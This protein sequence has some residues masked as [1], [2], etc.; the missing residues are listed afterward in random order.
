[1][2]ADNQIL[3]GTELLSE[4]VETR[5]A[6]RTTSS[7]D[8]FTILGHE[9]R[10]PLSALNFALEAWPTTKDEPQLE[11]ELLQ[12]MRRQVAQLTRLCTDMLDAGKKSQADLSI[13]QSTINLEQ[14]IK[15]ACEEIRPFITQCGLSI[16]IANTEQPLTLLGDESKLTQVFANLLHNAAKFTDQHGQLHIAVAR[17]GDTAVVSVRDSGCGMCDERVQE[18]FRPPRSTLYCSRGPGG[19][20][21]IGLQLAKSIVELHGG[22]IKAFSE[23]TGCGSEFVVTLPLAKIQNADLLTTSKNNFSDKEI[24]RSLL[25]HCL[26]VVVDDDRSIRFLMSRLL[27]TLEQSVTVA[28]SGEAA[29]KAILEVSPHLVFMDLQMQ[30]MSGY[31]LAREVRKRA[32][33]NE[34]VLIALSGNADLTSR[35]LAA[36]SGF[37]Q[38]LVKPISVGKLAQVIIGISAAR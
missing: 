29:L 22:T 14:V 5:T 38:Y 11:R 4:D 27:K 26:I 21:G 8:R 16:T 10:N 34:I 25:P 12:I 37:D 13:I 3:N 9:I 24:K 33:F 1:M 2:T 28:D 15:N 32:D 31:E 18:V 35:Q 36:E 17:G 30:G 20:L 19:G 7:D 23:G 6:R